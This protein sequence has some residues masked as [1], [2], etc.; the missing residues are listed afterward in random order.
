MWLLDLMEKET[1]RS[2]LAQEFENLEQS[3]VIA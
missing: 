1:L 2:Q 3:Q